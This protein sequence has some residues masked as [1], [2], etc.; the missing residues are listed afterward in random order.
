MWTQPEPFEPRFDALE[1]QLLTAIDLDS[2]GVDLASFVRASGLDFQTTR[3]VLDRLGRRRVLEPFVEA[4]EPLRWRPR[5]F[6]M[7][8]GG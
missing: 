6:A 3:S 1:T 2:P 7:W 4:G 8:I 5:P